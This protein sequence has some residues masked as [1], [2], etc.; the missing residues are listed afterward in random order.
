MVVGFEAMIS[1]QIITVQIKDKTKIDDCYFDCGT[2]TD[3][4]ISGESSLIL[5]FFLCHPFSI[6]IIIYHMQGLAASLV[7]KHVSVWK[8]Q[9]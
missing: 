9:G 1:S 7:T 6:S 4:A 8:G 2:A 3:G 5:F